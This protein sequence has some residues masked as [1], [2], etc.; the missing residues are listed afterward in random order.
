VWVSVGYFS[1]SHINTMY[2]DATRY[3]T[4][5]AIALVAVVILYA[6]HRLIRH[7]KGA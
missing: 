4:Y 3:Y 5:F 7:R 1:G 6:A 2:N